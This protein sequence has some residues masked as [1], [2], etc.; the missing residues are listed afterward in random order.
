MRSCDPRLIDCDHPVTHP[1]D[2]IDEIIA[3]VHFREPH[4][5]GDLALEPMFAL[6]RQNLGRYLGAKEQIQILRRAAD[7]RVLP[8]GESSG[9]CVGDTRSL[10]S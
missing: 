8:Q 3:S 10:Q 1:R 4:G 2:Q 6:E 9:N 7:S 5:V